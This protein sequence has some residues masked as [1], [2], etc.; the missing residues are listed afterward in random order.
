MELLRLLRNIKDMK[1]NIEISP[2]LFHDGIGEEIYDLL[3]DIEKYLTKCKEQIDNK[4]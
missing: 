3:S 1:L 4:K 2:E